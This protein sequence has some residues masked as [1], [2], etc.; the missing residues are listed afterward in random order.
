MKAIIGLALEPFLSR[1]FVV[2]DELPVGSLS[3]FLQEKEN[4]KYQKNFLAVCTILVE[5][6][7]QVMF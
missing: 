4:R 5:K 1:G 3:K 7:Y 6:R 2:K